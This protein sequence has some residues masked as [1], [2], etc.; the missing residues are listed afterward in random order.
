[1]EKA[2]LLPTGKKDSN[3]TCRKKVRKRLRTGNPPVQYVCECLP[4]TRRSPRSE[5]DGNEEAVLPEIERPDGRFPPDYWPVSRVHHRLRLSVVRKNY[6]SCPVL[7]EKPA[8]SPP[9][10]RGLDRICCKRTSKIPELGIP[11]QAYS[12]NAYLASVN[13]TVLRSL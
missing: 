5:I 13:S 12:L 4:R 7:S 1:M 8:S 9:R 10:R 11:D 2:I 3:R 6:N